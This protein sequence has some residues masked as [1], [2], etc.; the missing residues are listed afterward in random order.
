M[1]QVK[2][3]SWI[4]VGN[5]TRT[6][7]FPVILLLIRPKSRFDPWTNDTSPMEKDKGP[8]SDSLAHH[9]L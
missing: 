2:K 8:Y 7:L 1:N 6:H 4:L 3:F 9:S 5:L